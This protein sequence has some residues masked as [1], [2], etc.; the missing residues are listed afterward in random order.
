MNI[1]FC[2]PD[3]TPKMQKF[4]IAML[5]TLLRATDV[6]VSYCIG[7]SEYIN[8]P[9]NQMKLLKTGHFFLHEFMNVFVLESGAPTVKLRYNFAQASIYKRSVLLLHRGFLPA[10]RFFDV[11]KHHKW[12]TN[13]Q[14]K[15]YGLTDFEQIIANFLRAN[16]IAYDWDDRMFTMSAFRLLESKEIY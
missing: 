12:P 6:H 14:I 7:D 1:Y 16:N 4:Y 2:A 13:I 9:P 3:T 10:C 11:I 5:T 8:L 15:K